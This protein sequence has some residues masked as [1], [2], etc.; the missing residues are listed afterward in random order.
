[1]V[2][3]CKGGKHEFGQ[4]EYVSD[5]SCKQ[6]RKC[7]RDGYEEKRIEHAYVYL[8]DRNSS[9]CQK[10]TRCKDELPHSWS[11]TSESYTEEYG[12]IKSF[13]CS[14]CKVTGDSLN[15]IDPL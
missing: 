11:K 7:N 5:H 9:V 4:W 3:K 2:K 12:N 13:K 14:K 8:N 10:C 1:M 15:M 6:V